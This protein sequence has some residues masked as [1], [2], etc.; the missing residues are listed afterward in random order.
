MLGK[1][2][3]VGRSTGRPA[4]TRVRQRPAVVSGRGE[5]DGLLYLCI[6]AFGRGPGGRQAVVEGC[7]L[8]AFSASA[9]LDVT[10]DDFNPVICVVLT[11]V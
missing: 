9:E 6:L 3:R 1:R 8:N 2:A 5:T 11:S 4:N 7:V 10:A